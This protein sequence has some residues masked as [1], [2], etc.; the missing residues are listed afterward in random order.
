M[1]SDSSFQPRGSCDVLVIAFA[2]MDIQRTSSKCAACVSAA[3]KEIPVT[4]V[5][6]S[7]RCCVINA[8]DGTEVILCGKTWNWMVW[9]QNII[10]SWILNVKKC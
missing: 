5:E 4:V 9:S 6:P 7:Y 8:F 1:V 3:W 2:C 10:Q